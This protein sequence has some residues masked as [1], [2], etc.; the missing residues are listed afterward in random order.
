MFGP[1]IRNSEG[2]PGTQTPRWAWAPAAHSSRKDRPPAPTISI[3]NMNSVVL[4][5]VPQI[6]Q[7][8]SRTTPSAVTTPEPDS[9][10]IG[11][12]DEL[13][14][15]PLE[16]RQVVRAEQDALA[17]ERVVRPCLA[18]DLGVA[19]LP[20]HEQRR[21]Q[22]PDPP[23]RPRV[24]DHHRQRLGVVVD[25]P[26]PERLH[27]GHVP[28]RRPHH[29]RVG[30]VAPRQEPVA[31]PLEHVQPRRSLRDLRHEL[32]R[33]RAGPDH[34]HALAGQVERVV[35]PGRV[36]A[37]ARELVDALDPRDRPAGG[38]AR[39]RSPPRPPA[40]SARPPPPPSTTTT[41][42]SQRHD[43][44]STPCRTSPIDSEVPRHLL[45]IPEDLRLRRADPRPVA[46]LRERERV[47][48]TRHVAGAARVVVVVPRPADAR[49]PLEHGHIVEPVP[50]Q[51]DRSREAAEPG[52]DD[53]DPQS[54]FPGHGTREKPTRRLRA[55]Q[56]PRARRLRAPA[57]PAPPSATRSTP[58]AGR[59]RARPWSAA[60]AACPD[61]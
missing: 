52:A 31:G 58:R 43:T 10:A 55:L 17:S 18:P 28:D 8:T 32:D 54:A 11:S 6:T 22:P 25:E 57:R 9:R 5:P 41:P 35:P 21:A 47:Q 23:D 61:T 19:Q 48:V 49:R 40:T 13:D 20:A 29:R 44:T 50:A 1:Y 42:S 12:S 2:K 7:S 27:P 59:G 4:N 36:E 53:H 46:A 14:V 45:E 38:A 39:W 60:G 34:R 3:G 26:P 24:A 51:L 16:R 56:D 37:H 30:A 15:R 33:A